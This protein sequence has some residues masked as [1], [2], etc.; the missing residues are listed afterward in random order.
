MT[1][2]NQPILEVKHPALISSSG[3]HWN[4]TFRWIDAA[5]RWGC[6]TPS[7]FYRLPKEEKLDI[8][9]WYE[10]RWRIDAINDYEMQAKA[11]RAAKR[12]TKT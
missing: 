6:P 9:S 4:S 10:A 5:Q 3:W 11:A 8:L 1:W 7:H 2:H 12:K